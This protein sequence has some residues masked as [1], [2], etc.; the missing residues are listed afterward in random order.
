M[1]EKTM[2]HHYVMLAVNLGLSL[3]VM[4]LAMF[5]MIFSWGE[6]I[7]NINF[8]Y[9]ALVMWAPMAVIMLLTMRSMYM[10]RKL[11]VVLHVAFVAIFVLALIGIRAQGLVGDRQFVQS[12]IPHHS[13]ALLMC[14]E[15]ALKDAELRELCYGANGIMESQKREIAQMK[16]ILKR[17]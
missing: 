6:F 15:A 10:N 1:S 2:K 13:G 16:A 12:M 9:M 7:Q 3:L 17:L 4:Y 8:L 14:K 5:A 11:N